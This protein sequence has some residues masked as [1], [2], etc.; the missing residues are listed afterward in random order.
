MLIRG[1]TRLFFP[2]ALLVFF[3]LAQLKRNLFPGS[4]SVG[5]GRWAKAIVVPLKLSPDLS[6]SKSGPDLDL[7]KSLDADDD[8]IHLDLEEVP[9]SDGNLV[10]PS[11]Q[12]QQQQQEEEEEEEEEEAAAEILGQPPDSETTAQEKPGYTHNTIF[13]LSTA[14]GTYFDIS[15]GNHKTLNPN[16]IPHP[17]S[18]D[19]WIIVAQQKAGD[20]Q[21]GRHSAVSVQLVCDASFG[22]SDGSAANDRDSHSLP[23][24][25]SGS[26]SETLSCITP[27]AVLP[28][29][30]TS[31]G[32]R[33][34]GRWS[35]LSLNIGPHDA[36]LFYGPELPYII[37]GSN[38][39][40]TCFGQWMHDF[41]KLVSWL[42]SSSFNEDPS[43][44]STQT[45]KNTEMFS[46]AAELYRPPP[47]GQIEKNWFIFWNPAGDA[48]VHYDVWP[49]RSFAKIETIQG[50]KLLVDESS[51]SL[52]VGPDLAFLASTSD[53]TCMDRYMP[54]VR[55]KSEEFIHQATNS[56]SITL[57]KRSEPDCQPTDMNTFIFTIFQKK[58]HVGFGASSYEPYVMLFRRTAPFEIHSISTKPFWIHG[59]KSSLQEE[60]THEMIYITSMSWKSHR[61]KYHGYSDD[62]LFLAFGIDDSRTAGIDFTASELLKDMGLCMNSLLDPGKSYIGLA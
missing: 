20:D 14:S 21:E 50:N 42:S 39:H 11:G 51:V 18:S 37:Y 26:N 17:S 46:A 9:F 12:Q 7:S 60:G 38:S 32:N 44:Q 1:V 52:T 56:L 15:F 57:C 13:S 29:E 53:M 28:I 16:I 41:R 47:Y 54:Q 36:R 22:S 43:S 48:Y 23:T 31:S 30:A 8:D 10:Q 27:P 3:T 35:P 59:R 25:R 34:Q 2:I 55:D 58:A 4:W 5:Y 45:E 19:K 24:S 6:H 61:Q 40:F 49:Q 62:V 33:C